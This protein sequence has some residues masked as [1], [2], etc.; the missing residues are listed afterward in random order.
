MN[1]IKP[2]KSD[3]T[4]V[5]RLVMTVLSEWLRTSMQIKCCI[6]NGGETFLKLDM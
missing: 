6:F 1:A 4:N 3:A 5:H 2:D